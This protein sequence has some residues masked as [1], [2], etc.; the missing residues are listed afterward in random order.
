[1][2]NKIN[3][4][5]EDALEI[6]L[7]T[8]KKIIEGNSDIL[9]VI[10]ACFIV[11]SDL[12]KKEDLEWIEGELSGHK[13]APGYRKISLPR[14]GG[15]H[16]FIYEKLHFP[17]S[18]FKYYRDNKKNLTVVCP[19][20]NL[21]LR[22][23]H[24]TEMIEYITNKCLKFLTECTSEL[25]YG[26]Y[27]QSI[28]EEIRKNVDSNLEKIDEKISQEMQSIYLNLRS[29]N[30]AD[31]I[32]VAH[33]CRRIL[34]FMAD[35]VFPAKEGKYKLKNG[36]EL[37]IKD[38]QFINRLICFFDEKNS[39]LTSSECHY[40]SNLNEEVEKGEHEAKISQEECSIMSLHTYLII[41]EVLKYI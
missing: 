38:N 28:F 41:N 34:K 20:H 33:S 22:P 3:S 17:I 40:L 16:E 29:Q 35:K 24:C 5:Q 1:M 9:E 37:E 13:T 30:P 27:V 8:R 11:A 7:T 10:R 31:K 4:P 23:D 18:T 36:Y 39:K 2:E 15:S 25:L 6:A 19:K 26:G 14:L 32:K 21:E 12:S